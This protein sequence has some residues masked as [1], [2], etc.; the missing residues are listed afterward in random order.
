M[1]VSLFD[2][3]IYRDLLSDHDT[4]T[5]FGDAAE[6]RALL[7]TEAAL[8][9]A[10]AAVGVIPTHAA[11]AIT[12]AAHALT[13]DPDSLRSGTALAGVPIP[14][15]L[16]ALRTASGEFA[17]YVHWGVTSQD[18][19]DT[20]LILRLK[21]ASDILE[22]RLSRLARLLVKQADEHRLTVMAGRTRFQQAVPI[23]YGL[24]AAGWLSALCRHRV[25]LTQLRERAFVAQLGGAAGTL[26][27]LGSDG[28]DVRTA[29]ARELGLA[30]CPIPWHT[31]RDGITEFAGW[32]SL[33]SATL[34][35]IG[36]D[37]LLLAQSEVGEVRL[38]AGGGSSA[39]PQK[40]NPV[41]AEIL[42]ALARANAGYL[43]TMHGAML[44][45]HE[46][47]GSG[48]TV[49][50][51]TLPQMVVAA[52]AGLARACDLMQGLYVDRARMRSAVDATRG[53]IMA[54]AACIALSA[55][56]P[57][58]EAEKLVAQACTEVSA[59]KKHLADELSALVTPPF[60]AEALR[61]PTTYLGASETF[62]DAVLAEAAS[63][64]PAD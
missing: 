54:E 64:F 6:L 48:W 9:R 43:S 58:M 35:K 23:T 51:L 11:A 47:S 57:R 8:A 3:A 32:L 61:D 17:S 49:E 45:E 15:L 22:Q 38:A 1:T 39:M 14:A 28:A 33:V 42:V 59:G 19:V 46:R 60:D 26:A 52:G 34:G 30:T 21:T 20:A 16:T 29:F 41:A 56:M 2:S 63:V 25:R 62:I 5:L 44:Q 12:K 24:K 10:Q 53:L 13:I 31:Q 55:T 37:L 40:A 27:A 18:I 50:W 4:A 7:D 36:G